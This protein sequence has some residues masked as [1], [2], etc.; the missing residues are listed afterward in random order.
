MWRDVIDYKG[1]YQVSDVGGV[2]SLDF[3]EMVTNRWGSKTIRN[4]KGKTLQ[5]QMFP[6]G[7]LCVRLGRGNCEL[8]HRLV[9]RAFVPGDTALQVNHK[10]GIR[11]DNRA[12]NLE[13]LSCAENHKH[14]Y[15][16]LSRKQHVWTTPVT[17]VKGGV[18]M[19]YESVLSAANSIGVAPGSISS[20]HHRGHLCQGFGVIYG[21]R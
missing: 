11:A 14:S 6:N 5:P 9:A 16:E 18:S 8:A 4:R 17:L 1:R 13:W 10:N 2:R 12:E 20:A 15:R 3:A 21:A 19:F 7:Y